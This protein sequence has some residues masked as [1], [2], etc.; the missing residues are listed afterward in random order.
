MTDALDWVLV[1]RLQAGIPLCARPYREIGEACGMEETEVLER[2]GR[3]CQ[4]G[5]IRRLG[6]RVSHR[7]AGLHG[8]V[9]VVWQVPADRVEEVGRTCAREAAI[10]HCYEREPQ[11]DL[12]YNLYTMF[13]APDLA[14]AHKLVEELSRAIAI[15]DFVLLPTVRELKKSSP[16]FRP[17]AGDGQ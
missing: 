11:P 12:P 4:Q 16:R 13:H 5:L 15:S 6:A 2:I 10:S 1:E 3:L 17:P 14:A 7:R 8:N 9:M